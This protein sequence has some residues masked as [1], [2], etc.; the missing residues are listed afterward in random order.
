VVET[1][2]QVM[3]SPYRWG[4]SDTNGFDC[5]GLIRYAYARH[6]VRLPRVSSD[7]LRE[8]RAVALEVDSLLPGDI[9]GFAGEPG[10]KATHVGLYVGGGQFLHSSPRGVRLSS[11][12]NPYWRRHFT[13]ARR[14]VTG[15]RTYSR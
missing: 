13:A 5:S 1:A 4:G 8:G 11:L 10:G 6:G 12:G 15:A 7:Q 9:L 2:L 3:G 14:I